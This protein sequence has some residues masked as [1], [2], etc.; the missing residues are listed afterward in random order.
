M[1]WIQYA[2]ARHAAQTAARI[3][4]GEELTPAELLYAR[5]SFNQISVTPAFYLTS[6]AARANILNALASDQ[7]HRN[8]KQ[9][10]NALCFAA[11]TRGRRLKTKNHEVPMYDQQPR[12]PNFSELA[13]LARLNWQLPQAEPED[14]EPEPDQDDTFKFCPYCERP[15]QFGEL[16]G[17]CI[18]EI[19]R[20]NRRH[21]EEN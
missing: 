12:R 9:V 7:I 3:N 10:F 17:D 16:C 8:T 18:A 5:Q 15:N 20:I 6:P 21:Q 14:A 2:I 11:F 13:I 4:A 1:N 19:D